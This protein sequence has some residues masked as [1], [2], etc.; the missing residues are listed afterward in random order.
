MGDGVWIWVVV[1]GYVGVVMWEWVDW[2][3][4]GCIAGVVV[5]QWFW[6]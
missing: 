3:I 2:C 1:C 4:S 5:D 6:D